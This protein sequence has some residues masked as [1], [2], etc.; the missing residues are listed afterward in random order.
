MAMIQLRAMA[1]KRRTSQHQ[2]LIDPRIEDQMRDGGGDPNTD[3]KGY[4]R[5]QKIFSKK[6]KAKEDMPRID[7]K[8]NK[9]NYG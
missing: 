8:G 9:I 4:S 3:T 2:P 7:M 5:L 1:T 6:K